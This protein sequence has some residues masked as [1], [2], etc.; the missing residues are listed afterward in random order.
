[1]T[2]AVSAKERLN[3]NISTM[4]V[5]LALAMVNTMSQEG[6]RVLQGSR[7]SNSPYRI[8]NRTGYPVFIW[9]DIDGH[10]GVKDV[11]ST[12]INHGKTVEWRFDDWKTMREVRYFLL[13]DSN[14]VTH[15]D[16]QARF[17]NWS[18]QYWPTFCR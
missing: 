1:M 6:E 10:S 8:V 18:Q 15:S 11:P 9:S 7:G 16:C 14:N 3:V 17:F 4:F 12:Q 13:Y 5:E 2:L